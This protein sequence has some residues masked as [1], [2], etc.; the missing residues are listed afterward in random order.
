M[1][2]AAARVFPSRLRR[3]QSRSRHSARPQRWARRCPREPEKAPEPPGRRT[4]LAGGD[5]KKPKG[6]MKI[7][8]GCGK[9]RSFRAA[10]RQ[11]ICA[12][13][14]AGQQ[15]AN[16]PAVRVSVTGPVQ[17][18]DASRTYGDWPN[19]DRTPTGSRQTGRCAGSRGQGEL[20][21]RD[22]VPDRGT[23]PTSHGARFVRAAFRRRQTAA[24]RC[25]GSRS[26]RRQDISLLRMGATQGAEDIVL[27]S[28]SAGG[29]HRRRSLQLQSRPGKSRGSFREKVVMAP[30]A[31]ECTGAGPSDTRT[32]GTPVP[33][34][35]AYGRRVE[36]RPSSAARG[37]DPAV[38]AR[39]GP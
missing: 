29:Q 37:P 7:Y 15:T 25:S 30:Q 38:G 9:R 20:L 19:R 22:P 26:P 21:A 5:G 8:W 23:P 1:M 18:R 16:I 2:H 27:W 32:M 39:S 28:S 4:G 10:D 3:A 13:I 36:P 17:R 24:C 34:F 31:T 14:V 11:S 33:R 35:I 12:K 6:R